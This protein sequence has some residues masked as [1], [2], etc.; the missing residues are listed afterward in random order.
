MG[1]FI[2]VYRPD[3]KT[4]ETFLSEFQELLELINPSHNE[5]F[6]TGDINLHLE[7]CDSP[8]TISFCEILESFDYK[9]HVKS[10]T[11]IHG[12][13]LD[14]IISRSSCDSVKTVSVF[15]GISDHFLVL[16]NLNYAKSKPIKQKVSFRSFRNFDLGQFRKDIQNSDLI[17]N[18]KSDLSALID[19]YNLTL[20]NILN[21]HAPL[22]SKYVSEKPIAPWIN[23]HIVT[24]KRERRRLERAWRK[25]RSA[26][27]RSRYTRQCHL[28]NRTMAT[29][30]A[31]F[32]SNIISENSDDPR[33]L[34]KTINSV[35]HRKPTPSLPDHDSPDLLCQ[36]FS[37]FFV[38]KISK[39]R[40]AF[41]PRSPDTSIDL[42]SGDSIHSLSSFSSASS[43]EI[44]KL[45]TCS[46]NSYCDLD[47]MPTSLTKQCIDILIHPISEILNKAL[48]LGTFPESFKK[49][50]VTPLLKKASL[51]KNELK[52]Y[53]P[54]SNLSFLSKLLEKLVA[55]RLNTHLTTHSL[56][57]KF[58]SAYKKTHSTETA[59]LRV[60][61]DILRSMDRGELTA[62]SLL[63]LSAAFDT[64]DHQ[65]LLKRLNSCYN[66][67]GCALNWFESY[68]VNRR[69]QVKVNGVLS[70]GVCL[71]YGVPQG[72][73][74]GPVL[75]TLYTAALSQ[76]IDRHKLNHHLY[77]DDTQIYIS[78]SSN[79]AVDSLRMLQAC[80]TEVSS[81]M[82][83][84]MLKLNPEKTEFMIIGSRQQRKKVEHLFPFQFLCQDIRPTT[85]AKNLG[86]LFDHGLFLKKHVAQLCKVCFYHIRDL[87]RIRR[88]ISTD[89]A[90]AIASALINSRF[91][92]CN[93]LLYGIADCDLSRLQRVQNCLARVVCNA[94]RL[95]P[96]SPLLKRLHW[97]PLKH[98]VRFK[99]AS[100]AHRVF[101][102][103]E[104]SYLYDVLRPVQGSKQLRSMTNNSFSL[105]SVRTNWGMRA[106][107]FSAP[108]IW[109]ALP[110]A[111]KKEHVVT[112][113]RRKLKTFLFGQAFP[114]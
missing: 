78:F 46:P 93:S 98:R 74:L 19:Q 7:K 24:L 72:S 21:K 81:W 28:C 85:S 113:F 64:V 109:N 84:S 54:I 59:L 17:K 106:L 8:S 31:D 16:A 30:K 18:P 100:I 107:S 15:D 69:Q 94:S 71:D 12:H 55:A 37:D 68:L 32:Y 89:T 51:D 45:I 61:N 65:I 38:N 53:R 60:Q 14:I 27:D 47:P 43:N 114:P 63:D 79:K 40:Q 82:S 2:C 83:N 97:L 6:I 13:I 41:P 56:L 110:S 101:Y 76:I 96:S 9:Q 3:P 1:L 111:V 73:V 44:I 66:V 34:W 75:F 4:T 90:R 77:A 103:K 105:P 92:Y 104:P 52:N 10:S 29:A 50:H 33:K 62:L 5:I 49:A 42:V 20:K 88:C 99:L 70:K 22:K 87:R 23:P 26:Y 48:L 39:I 112:T 91:D 86:V 67:S 102:T 58:Q 95:S 36:K 108:Y 11:H 25:S 80:A 35:L 57:N